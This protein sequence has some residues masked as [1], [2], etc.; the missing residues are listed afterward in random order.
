MAI[1]K[2][3]TQDFLYN[4]PTERIA[5]HPLEQ[6]DDS[7]LLVV[8]LESGKRSDHCFRELTDQIPAGS[9]LILNDS[10]V[11]PARLPVFKATGGGAEIFLI[12]PLSPYL[13]PAQTLRLGSPARWNALFGGKRIQAGD[14]LR[15]A[16]KK[17]EARVLEKSGAQGQVELHWHPETT[18]LAD[19][20]E[21][22]GKIPLPPYMKREASPSD[23]ER[24][25]TV[26]AAQ[27]GSVAAPTAGLHFTP[28][29]LARLEK[30]GVRI[31]RLT[32][33]VG[34]GTFKPVEAA[35]VDAHAMHRERFEVSCEFLQTLAA[36]FEA[37]ERGDSYAGPVIAVGTTS[38]RALESIYWLALMRFSAN[39]E[40]QSMTDLPQWLAYDQQ[41]T[42]LALRVSPAQALARL[43]DD[44]V[45]QRLPRLI[46]S[47]AL[48]IV[49]GYPFQ[50][51]D[52]LLTNFHQPGSSLMLLVAAWAGEGWRKIYDHA[53]RSDYRFL[54]YGDS[55]L[56]VRR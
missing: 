29:V 49:P 15:S 3:L 18:S 36:H 55:S 42:D 35:T 50:T 24:Y 43:R 8:D 12:D 5:Q 22:I 54:S 17:L 14:V 56:L 47:S 39:P 19:I 13:D 28:E 20:L 41:A 26:Y 38:L 25:Q 6:R 9:L 48:M 1:P 33:H 10:R 51:I 45:Q 11:L 21:E 4:L 52:R 46:A 7:K 2:V 37:R 40:T 16:D 34:A 23:Q 44:L 32:L 53:L 31:A 30:K 27:A